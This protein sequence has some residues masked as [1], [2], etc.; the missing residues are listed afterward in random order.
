MRPVHLSLITALALASSAGHAQ[1]VV[2]TGYI[3]SFNGQYFQATNWDVGAIPYNT[4][5]THFNI[6]LARVARLYN[7]TGGVTVN[8]FHA[9]AKGGVEILGDTHFTVNAA[10]TG[11]GLLLTR[12]RRAVM[13]LLDTGPMSLRRLESLDGV[14]TAHASSWTAPSGDRILRAQR[15]GGDAIVSMPSLRSIQIGSDAQS[16]GSAQITAVGAT[17]RTDLRARI[18]LPALTQVLGQVSWNASFGGIISAPSLLSLEG[19]AVQVR[20]STSRIDLGGATSANNAALEVS[21]GATLSLD[22]LVTAD[23]TLFL[24]DGPSSSIIAPNVITIPGV[25]TG[26]FV[27]G[28][29][30]LS[31]GGILGIDAVTVEESAQLSLAGDFVTDSTQGESVVGLLRMT[32]IGELEAFHADEGNTRAAPSMRLTVDTNASVSLVDTL[33]NNADALPDALY[34]QQGPNGEPALSIEPGGRLNLTADQH[35]YLHDGT[36][37]IDLLDLIGGDAG[38]F[39]FD[40]GEICLPVVEEPACPADLNH[41]DLIDFTDIQLFFEAFRKHDPIADFDAD[42]RVDPNDARVFIELYLTKCG[43]TTTDWN[44]HGIG[45]G[46]VMRTTSS[47]LKTKRSEKHPEEEADKHPDRRPL[48]L[49]STRGKKSRSKRGHR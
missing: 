47:M 5:T 12:E 18:D 1:D 35:V 6:S 43:T 9:T 46:R 30:A 16:L 24:A 41:D 26:A 10:V 31:L 44:G 32:G 36:A 23:G 33:D 34:L 20:D 38:C 3:G 27:T 15:I 21:D 17:Y 22:A 11:E 13:T 4:A 29:A 48:K 19:H 7:N 45:I 40:R 8:G 28:G 49:T 25:G 2:S 39:A 37:W 14:I 42:G